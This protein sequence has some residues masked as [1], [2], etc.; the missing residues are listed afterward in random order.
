MGLDSFSC[1][2]DM[3]VQPSAV[4]SATGCPDKAIFG[5]VLVLILAFGSPQHQVDRKLWLGVSII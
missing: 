4:F 5:G 1:P 3:I 2:G